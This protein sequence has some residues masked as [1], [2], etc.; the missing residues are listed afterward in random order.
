MHNYLYLSDVFFVGAW[1]SCFLLC[2]TGL[3]ICA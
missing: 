3:S 1:L 2:R